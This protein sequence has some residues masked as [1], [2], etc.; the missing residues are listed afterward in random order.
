MSQQSSAPADSLAA[1]ATLTDEITLQQVYLVSLNDS[2]GD[3]SARKAEIEAEIAILRKELSAI[4]ASS[5]HA[6]ASSTSHDNS[7]TRPPDIGR[8]KMNSTVARGSNAGY[9][10]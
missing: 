7:Y 3:Q 5:S 2:S 6:Q 8:S 4:Q 9:Q 10:C 1:I